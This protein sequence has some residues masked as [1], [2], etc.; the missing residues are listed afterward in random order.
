MQNAEHHQQ[1]DAEQGDVGAQF[2]PGWI[3]GI[4]RQVHAHRLGGDGQ[5]CQ[6][7]QHQGKGRRGQYRRKKAP[8]AHGEGRKQIEVLR[9]A[10][11]CRHAAQIRCDRLQNHDENSPFLLAAKAERRE[12]EGHERDQRHVV[13]YD[14]AGKEA[15]QYQHLRQAA[16]VLDAHER[17]CDQPVEHAHVLQPP[18]QEHQGKQQ[19][20]HPHIDIGGIPRIRRNKAHRQQRKQQ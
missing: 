13:G 3:P 7:Q 2:N 4:L 19:R 20:Q 18:D 9:V 1:V 6:Q 5:R 11:G 8:R 12:A 16:Q 17:F 10:D 15:H 14:H